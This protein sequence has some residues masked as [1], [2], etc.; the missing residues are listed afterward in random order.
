M[1]RIL[2]LLTGFFLLAANCFAM[3]LEQ[4]VEIGKVTFPPMGY[5]AVEG[6]T[7]HTGTPFSQQYI[8][9]YHLNKNK[10]QPIYD[11]GVAIFGNG[12]DAIYF[13]YDARDGKPDHNIVSKMGSRDIKNTVDVG[14]GIPTHINLL[15]TDSGIDLYLLMSEDASGLVGCTYTLLGRRND[16]IFVKYFNTY[17]MR[18][19]YFGKARGIYFSQ[20]SI[21]DDSIIIEYQ[22]FHRELGQYGE[23]VTEGEFRFKWD[24]SAQWFGVEQV[25][26]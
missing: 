22:R 12:S 14:I 23:R 3:K 13:H 7:S 15:K 2:I 17:E 1:N 8:D 20:C 21:Q 4:P 25:I 16:G 10:I 24:E 18:S 26:F 19:K 6:A 11:K 9:A 5:F